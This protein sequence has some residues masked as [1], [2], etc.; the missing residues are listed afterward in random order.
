MHVDL[1]WFDPS[2]GCIPLPML[3]ITQIAFSKE[4]S[5]IKVQPLSLWSLYSPQPIAIALVITCNLERT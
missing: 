4:Q 5:R 1:K 3:R 2:D